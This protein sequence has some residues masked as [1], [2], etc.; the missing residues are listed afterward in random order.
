MNIVF[1]LLRLSF[2]MSLNNDQKELHR[3]PVVVYSTIYEDFVSPIP[4][5]PFRISVK[6]AKIL[7]HYG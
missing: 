2:F 3:L 7:E 5:F 1:A 4:L 6:Q